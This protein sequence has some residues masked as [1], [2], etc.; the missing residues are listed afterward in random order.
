MLFGNESLK[1][2]V[3]AIKKICNSQSTYRRPKRLQLYCVKINLS[4]G[5][6]AE[7]KR[8]YKPLGMLCIGNT[9]TVHLQTAVLSFAISLILFLSYSKSR[10]RVRYM[11]LDEEKS[12]I[13]YNKEKKKR[14][15]L[16][17]SCAH[18]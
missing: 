18:N 11:L 7:T 12:W 5:V 15:I 6:T 16:V 1:M 17:T 13:G 10:M 14:P 3:F 4:V 2:C 8:E 9:P